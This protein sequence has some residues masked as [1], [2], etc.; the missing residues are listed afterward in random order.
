MRYRHHNL[1]SAMSAARQ[2]LNSMAKYGR[3][4]EPSTYVPPPDSLP[5]QR[6]VIESKAD[7]A[8]YLVATIERA[9]I[10]EAPYARLYAGTGNLARAIRL[11]STREYRAIVQTQDGAI[12]YSNDKPI[13]ED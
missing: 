2:R 11:A 8:V 4:R 9:A 10:G 3:M 6:T 12:V 7:T 1:P 13:P 5:N